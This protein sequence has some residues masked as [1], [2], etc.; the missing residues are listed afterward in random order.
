MF[1]FDDDEI[2]IDYKGKVDG[3]QIKFSRKVG[4]FATEELIAKRVK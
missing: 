3:D 4:D 1:K 2:R